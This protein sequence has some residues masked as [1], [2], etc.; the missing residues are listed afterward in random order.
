MGRGFKSVRNE[1]EQQQQQNQNEPQSRSKPLQWVSDLDSKLSDLNLP[2]MKVLGICAL[3]AVL[4]SRALS[5]PAPTQQ[6]K[7]QQKLPATG[8]RVRST[9]A[10]TMA[11][12]RAWQG[13]KASALGP[14]HDTS[15]LGQC[16]S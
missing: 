14:E 16:L 5:P 3:L 10:Q 7:Q 2:S 12:L 8:S 11:L 9:Y 13:A 4:G 15:M 1:Q 6:V